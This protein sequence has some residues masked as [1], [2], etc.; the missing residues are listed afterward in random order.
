MLVAAALIATFAMS[1]DYLIGYVNT[2]IVPCQHDSPWQDGKCVCDNT[3]GIFGGAFCEECQCEHL[4]ICRMSSAGATDTRWSCRCPN[5]QKWVGTTCNKCYAQL[6]KERCHGSCIDN[7]YG[8]QCN[9]F[10]SV[11]SD[12]DKSA[13]NCSALRA[14]GGTCN[15]CN[16]HGACTPQGECECADGWFTGRDGQQCKM[17]C[18]DCPAERGRCQSIGGQLQCVC[19]PG[20][21]GNSCEQTCGSN[22]NKVCS[23]HG[24][25][26]VLLGSGLQCSCDTHYV[27]VNCSAKCPGRTVISSPCSGHGTCALSPADSS[28]AVCNCAAN[29]KSYDCSCKDEHTCNGRGTCNP[30]YDGTNAICVCDTHFDGSRCE[31]CVQNWWGADCH[32]YCDP[33]GLEANASVSQINCHGHGVCELQTTDKVESITC[34]CQSNYESTEYCATCEQAYYPKVLIESSLDSCSIPCA[35]ENEC[36]NKG[37]CNPKYDGTNFLCKCDLNGVRLQFDTLDPSPEIGCSACKPNWFPKDLDLPAERC[38]RYC[39]ADGTTSN[40]NNIIHFGNDLTLGGDTDAQNLCRTYTQDELVT[41]G[42]DANCHVCSDNGKCDSEGDC[43]CNDGVTGSYCEID[44]GVNG[45]EACS[46]HGRC[47]R[48]DLELWFNPNSNNFRCDC[49]PYDPYTT[50]TRQRLVKNGFQVEPPPTANYYGQHCE[51]HCPTYNSEIC[52]GRGSC[53]TSVALSASGREKTC[54]RDE[55]CRNATLKDGRPDTELADTFCSV[56]STPWDSVTQRFFE[57]GTDSPGYTQCTRYGSACIDTIYSVDWGNFCVQMLNGWYPNELNTRDCAFNPTYRKLTEEFFIG[58]Y[59]NNKTWCANALEELTPSLSNKCTSSSYQGDGQ[60]FLD[61]TLLCN[62]FTLQSSC[63]NDH[64]CI[65]DKTSAYIAT[66]DAEC[67]RLEKANCLGTCESDSNGVCS[68]KTYCRAK[69][70]EDAINEK[71]IETLCFDLDAPCVLDK[72]QTDTSCST[73]LTN[74]RQSAKSMGLDVSAADLFFTCHMYQNS[75]NPLRI[76]ASTPGNIAIDGKLSVLGRDVFVQEYRSAALQGRTVNT[77]CPLYEWEKASTFCPQHLDSVLSDK[78]WYRTEKD[79]WYAPWRVKCG[80]YSTLMKTET[81]AKNHRAAFKKEIPNI[82]CTVMNVGGNPAESKPWTLD[83]LTGEATDITYESRLTLFPKPYANN[84]CTLTENKVNARWGQRQWSHDEIE[85][86]FQETCQKYSESPA[87]PPVPMVPDFCT[88]HNP[89]GPNTVCTLCQDLTCVKCLHRTEIRPICNEKDVLC[90][91]GGNCTSRGMVA[92]TYKCAYDNITPFQNA[93]LEIE[94]HHQSYREINWLR[95]C[96]KVQSILLDLERQTAL[97]SR[98]ENPQAQ[99][100]SS[101]LVRFI[102]ATITVESP[103]EVVIRVDEQ[104]TDSILRVNCENEEEHF[105]SNATNTIQINK[106]CEFE[107]FGIYIVSSIKV[108]GTESLL[109]LVQTLSDTELSVAVTAAAVTPAGLQPFLKFGYHPVQQSWGHSNLV[110]FAKTAEYVEKHNAGS[111]DA[112]LQWKFQKEKEKIRISGWLFLSSDT[113]GEMRLLSNGKALLQMRVGPTSLQIGIS[114]KSYSKSTYPDKTEASQGRSWCDTDITSGW[115]PWYID[116]RYIAENH[117]V[118]DG[119]QRHHQQWEGTVSAGN[120]KLTT[121]LNHLSESRL[122]QTVGRL[123]HSFHTIASVSQDD[124]HTQCNAHANCLQWSWTEEDEHCYL[125]EKRCHEDDSCVH[126]THTLHSSHSHHVDAFVI[127]TDSSSSVTWAHLRQDEIVTDAPA[128]FHTQLSDFDKTINPA[129]HKLDY[130]PYLPDVTAVC[131]DLSSSFLLMPGYE[132]R[133][134]NDEPCPSVY[135]KNDMEKCGDYIQYK[136]PESGPDCSNFAGL[137]WTAYCYY[138]KSF[139]ATTSVDTTAGHYFPILGATSTV[140]SMEK[141]CNSSHTFEVAATE[142]C[143]KIGLPW[144]TQC[145]GRWDVYEDFCDTTCLNY[146]EQQLSSEIGDTS[147]CQKREK[148]LQLNISNNAATDKSCSLLVEKLIVTDFCLLQNAYHVEESLL[149]PD[150]DGSSCPEGCTNML[151]TIFDRSRWRNWCEDFS[152]GEVTGICARSSCDCDAQDYIGVDGQFCELTCPSGTENG[153]ELACSGRNGKCFAADFNQISADYNAQEDAGQYRDGPVVD[154]V[155][156]LPNYEPIWLAG[157]T[158]STTGIC[159]CSLGSG[160]SC[161]IPCDKCNNGTYGQQMASQ[162]GICD[163]YYGMCRTLPPFMRY[164]VK[165]TG[166]NGYNGDVGALLSYNTTNFVQMVWQ[167]PERFVYAADSLLFEESVKDMYDQ[168]GHSY[169]VEQEMSYAESSVS[170]GRTQSILLGLQIF[171]KIC[172]T[173]ERWK[174]AQPYIVGFDE[175]SAT[176]NNGV[177][178]QANLPLVLSQYNIPNFPKQCTT[179]RMG[180]YYLCFA[181]GHLHGMMVQNGTAAQMLV[182]ETGNDRLPKNGMT[183]ARASQTTVYAFGGNYEYN[184]YTML[185]DSSYSN[186]LYQIKIRQQLWGE[187]MVVLA[188]WSTLSTIGHS[189]P[190][191][192]WAPLHYSYNELYLL[193]TVGSTHTMFVLELTLDQSLPEWESA[194]TTTHNGQLINTRLIEDT[195]TD[196]KTVYIFLDQEVEGFTKENGFFAVLSNTTDPPLNIAN[197]E[198]LDVANSNVVECSVQYSKSDPSDTD[199]NW[200]LTVAG[201]VLADFQTEPIQ[202][203]LFVE[204]W[205]NLDGRSNSD[206]VHRFYNTIEWRVRPTLNVPTILEKVDIDGVMTLVERLYMQQARWKQSSMLPVLIALYQQ[207]QSTDVKDMRV[208]VPTGSPTDNFLNIVRQNDASIF[209]NFVTTLPGSGSPL[210]YADIEGDDYKRDVVLSGHFREFNLAQVQFPYKELLKFQT[211]IIEVVVEEWTPHNFE[212]SL[213][214]VGSTPEIKWTQ[215]SNV[216]TFYIVIHVEEWMYHQE[217]DATFQVEEEIHTGQKDW[218]A[219]F[220]M[221]VSKHAAPTSRMKK[222]SKDYLGYYGNHCSA[223]A[224]QSC[225]GTLAYTHLPCSGHGRCNAICNCECE[226]APSVLQHSPDAL[227]DIDW[228]DSP[229]RGDGCEITCPG[230]DGYD[231]NSI[232]THNP[233]ACQRDG[234]C[235]CDPGRTGDACQ[236]ECP[237]TVENGKKVVC[238]NNG[239]CGT[240][241]IEQKSSVL[242]QDVYRNRLSTI[243]GQHY[244]D[245]LLEY[246]GGDCVAENYQKLPGRFDEQLVQSFQNED[247]IDKS[248]LL[249]TVAVQECEQINS[250]LIARIA[251]Y[252]T[253]SYLSASC[254]GLTMSGGRYRPVQLREHRTLHPAG[255]KNVN[256]IF[257]CTYSDCVFVRHP[258]DQ[259]T[260]AN[261]DILVDPPKFELRGT[262]IHGFSS[263]QIIYNINGMKMTMTVVW[264]PQL[265]SINLFEHFVHNIEVNIVRMAGDYKSF[266]IILGNGNVEVKLYPSHYF[267]LSTASEIWLAPTLGTKYRRSEIPRGGFAFNPISPDTQEEMPLLY[268]DAAEHAC[269]IEED[270]LGIVRWKT[271]YR[272]TL[273]S[274]YTLKSVVGLSQMYGHTGDEDNLDFLGKMSLFYKGK[275]STDFSAPCS[276]VEARQSKYPM[277]SFETTYDIPIQHLDISSAIDKETGAIE[278][279]NGIWTNCWEKQPETANKLQCR[280][281]CRQQKWSGFAYSRQACLCYKITSTAIQLHKYYS[282]T[283]KTENN[284]CDTANRNNPKTFWKTIEE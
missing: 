39:A 215:Y 24:N 213:Q 203:F 220:N 13:E 281:T 192:Q 159:Q 61:A 49:L 23:G 182:L 90:N 76:E 169:G 79:N 157:P 74:L 271:L 43:T 56:M 35:R 94:E 112:G 119:V 262:Y 218:K 91:D 106:E 121:E 12:V 199:S 7:H 68:T 71:S 171:Q 32:L 145:L 88:V 184:D 110:T 161:S 135:V 162:Y 189:P 109:S 185:D 196:T 140:S 25:C 57:I 126:G 252:E 137:N 187:H 3:K 15:T 164:N 69:S 84:G 265:L 55:E 4:G 20:Y 127:D 37:E 243:N 242:T 214:M 193:S 229:Y 160:D 62:E 270:C 279:G 151:T 219:L 222:Q 14:S 78:K 223:S 259:A 133:V 142:E 9:T 114:N 244:V 266:S 136:Q 163:A 275:N 11:G 38:T 166:I 224:D 8:S 6:K 233:T 282:N 104:T 253:H 129:L 235:A 283:A 85:Q 257:Q 146:I 2:V 186:T 103:T 202:V 148:Y 73:G 96:D 230:Y 248:F 246:Y 156:P 45:R 221:V 237:F 107:T 251:L 216:L 102:S 47:I 226:V 167:N 256:D 245:A 83:C 105:Y 231:L 284:P 154:K 158:P 197:R 131:N 58:E 261:I 272:N 59:K 130:Q 195:K 125:Y 101:D 174:D 64:R 260:L 210:I 249:F 27:G 190:V 97:D 255:M 208:V 31:R 212:I 122:R 118:I 191:Q 75:V 240:R 92:N 66:T 82:E 250:D 143:A 65:Y 194:G 87:I 5:H 274:L 278:I 21:F 165:Y 201:N 51:Y 41:Y 205:L 48:D 33:Y 29:W 234:T 152:K 241:A 149:L 217:S 63:S 225:P 269:D 277:V 198:V 206:I 141:I 60:Q 170:I 120:C 263:G 95:H 19:Y 239:G 207:Y 147:I 204:E 258:D 99:R 180:S 26:Q 42:V 134:C 124:C 172:G 200:R 117:Q 247:K 227:A 98:W 89:C 183:F 28:T 123:S 181:D 176:T 175:S 80:E 150:L 72:N 54:K 108:D 179:I 22:N 113:K 177:R 280:D 144:F 67:S 44:C 77:T 1:V 115:I 188:D 100:V 264:T 155:L 267:Q 40:T 46:G 50:E 36:N 34:K 254:L 138:Q 232:C 228:K 132:T 238:S 173:S 53:D 70:C 276:I 10:C 81:A 273:F 139:N 168:N 17:G 236:F 18:Q 153:L 116:V 30:A 128:D 111:A 86:T 209:R 93:I 16:G 268:L 178:I 211:G 52:A